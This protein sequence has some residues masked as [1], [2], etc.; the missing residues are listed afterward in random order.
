MYTAYSL[1]NDCLSAS[2]LPRPFQKEFF[3]LT[4]SCIKEEYLRFF[5]L[6]LHCVVLITIV[7]VLILYL[8]HQ[9]NEISWRDKLINS[10]PW[11]QILFLVDIQ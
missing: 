8:S 6:I 1:S 10:Y 7:C 4:R 3:F 11:E 2:D 5:A 9:L